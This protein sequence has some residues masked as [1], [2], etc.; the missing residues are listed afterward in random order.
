VIPPP[1]EG[2]RLTRDEFERRYDAMPHLKK[3]ELI[4]GVVHV[5]SPVRCDQHGEPPSH[6][7]G[8]LYHYRWKT[9]GV[10]LADNASVRMDLVNMPQPDCLLFLPREFGG[11]A[12]V[13][14][15]GYVSGAP[16]L[17]A[18]VAAISAAYDLNDKLQAYQRNGVRE[19]LVWRVLDRQID[20]FVLREGGY[21]RLD[22]A[23]DGTLRSMVF[24]G[25][26]LDPAALMREN[27]DTLMGVLQRGLDSRE[28]AE[29][30]AGLQRTRAEQAG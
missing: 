7:E 24:P 18:E 19:Y 10:R 9:P 3:A 22:P 2:D 11:T 5:P 13:D 25:L 26:W 12:R 29:F 4:E 14:E 8:W 30:L 16:D 28:H 6:L 27:L 15:D 21:Q 17:I 20:W 1:K 23:E